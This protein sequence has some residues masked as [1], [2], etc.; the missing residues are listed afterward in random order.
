MKILQLANKV[1]FPPKDGGAVATINLSKGLKMT[2]NEIVL[3]AMNTKK[4]HVD[5]ET[6]IKSAAGIELISVDVD[7]DIKF[8]KALLNLFFSRKPYIAERFI[9]KKYADKL[10]S[11]LQHEKFDII[12]L[13]GLYLLPYIHLIRNY[14]DAVISYRAHNIEH[15]IWQ[16]IVKHERNA[17]KKVY[18]NSLSKRLKKFEISMMDSYDIILPITRRDADML[19]HLGNTKVCHVVPSGIAIHEKPIILKKQHVDFFH[20]GSLDWIPNQEGLIWFLERCWPAILDKNPDA[21]FYIAG[22]NAPID[23]IKKI[24]GKNVIYCGEVDSA[25]QFIKKH[26]IMI[27]P[28]L[29]GSGMRV[30][31]IE[32][33]LHGKTVVTTRMGA[34][35]IPVTHGKNIIIANSPAEFINNITHL[36][37]KDSAGIVKIGMQAYEFITNNFDNFAICKNLHR[38]YQKCLSAG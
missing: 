26:D 30:K 19:H 2:G 38:F 21:T 37:Q 31:I 25:E 8:H 18:L 17:I 33:M 9:Q 14:S 16:R 10:K 27:V 5:Q 28:L 34:E 22:R 32:G 36:L 24:S 20:L 6:A 3:L 11:L 7:T 13:E 15:E 12:Q 29:S 1:P 4:H 23:F 35:G